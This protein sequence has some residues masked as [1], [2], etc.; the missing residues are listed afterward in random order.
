MLHAAA[1]DIPHPA[2]GRQ[3]F[4]APTPSAFQNALKS[5]GLEQASS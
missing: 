1:L 2:G 4:E 3:I 5:L